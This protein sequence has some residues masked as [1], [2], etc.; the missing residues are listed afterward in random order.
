VDRL[1]GSGQ[2]HQTLY[3]GAKGEELAGFGPWLVRL[4]PAGLL[5]D[6]VRD[7]WGK[8]WGVYLTCDAGLADVRRHL[9]K[10]LM[11]KLPDGREVYFRFYDPRVLRTY[12]PACLPDEMASFFGPIRR[13]ILE[14]PDPAEVLEFGEKYADWRKVALAA[15]A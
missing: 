15:G 5:E 2:E 10:F 9:R 7:G 14:G 13:Y 4:T 11:A 8:S 6:L 3:D 1:K 12:L